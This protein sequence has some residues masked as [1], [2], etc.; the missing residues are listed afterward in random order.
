MNRRPHELRVI[1]EKA[2]LGARIFALQAFLESPLLARV[3]L[4]EQ[5]RLKAQLAVM[6]KY[7]GILDTRIAAFTPVPD[8]EAN[9]YPAAETQPAADLISVDDF[10]QHVDLWHARCMEQG[11]RMLEIPEGTTIQLEDQKNPGELVEMDLNGPYLQV[12]RVGVLTVL[13]LFKDLPFGVSVE[14]AAPEGEPT[15]DDAAEG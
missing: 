15:N 2:E 3:D 6:E 5:E 7:L 10:A 9:I 13:H 12:F 14:D 11:N 4:D 1:G 8:G